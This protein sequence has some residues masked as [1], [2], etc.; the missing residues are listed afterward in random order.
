MS[1]PLVKLSQ[2]V[3]A[4]VLF[5]AS[6][7]A[8]APGMAARPADAWVYVANDKAG[9]MKELLAA[10]WDPNTRYRGQPALMQAVRDGSWTVFDV[11]A[12]DRRTDINATNA[13]DETPLMYLAVQGQTAR[14]QVLIARGA[15]VNRLGWTP[16]HYAASTGHVDTAKLLL[17]HQAIVNAPGPDGT[18]PL[19]MAGRSGSREM[20][21]LLL[22]AGADPTMRSLQ[23]LDAA[24]W[25]R[26]A[27]YEQ[28]AGLLE[29]AAD[30]RRRSR[31]SA[32]TGNDGS[33][34]APNAPQPVQGSAPT[35]VRA[36]TAAPAPSPA[37]IAPA[38]GERN[39]SGVSGVGLDSY[40]APAKP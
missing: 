35:A 36:P 15:K 11:L 6:L 23:G 5:S 37:N 10:G 25:A 39:L 2:A 1:F 20:A 26:S 21:Q 28:L 9:D 19:M 30:S 31:A 12:A 32:G 13:S 18:T 34:T 14:A 3:C 24:A 27:K 17:S 33:A 29:A 4:A 38:T 40:D 7:A 16:L 8:A 22:D